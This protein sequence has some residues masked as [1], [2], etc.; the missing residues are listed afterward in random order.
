M[1]SWGQK[2]QMLIITY[3]LLL[4]GVI[5]AVV[6]FLLIYQ[7]PSCNDGIHNGYEDGIDCG[8]TCAHVCSFDASE[9]TVQWARAFK[10]GQGVYNFAALVENPNFNVGAN[11]AY[12][13]RAY[14]PDNVLI[15]EITNSVVLAPKE[16]R[17][18]FE[19]LININNQEIARTF[20]DFG[21]HE[22]WYHL[23]PLDLAI[24]TPSYRLQQ[25]RS[26]P[27]LMVELRNSD[28]HEASNLIVHAILYN[29]AE[30]VEQVSQTYVESIPALGTREAFFSWRNKF[31]NPVVRVE[32]LVV[33]GSP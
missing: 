29:E 2:R 7:A 23:S 24:T 33:S 21:G 10:V 27:S 20:F 9:P 22:G 28:I 1:S 12:T 31:E 4:V 5:I 26:T 15:R 11:I 30:N 6:Y 17:I 14:N 8:G 3:L 16:K 13:F 19:P 25:D 32:V 18:I